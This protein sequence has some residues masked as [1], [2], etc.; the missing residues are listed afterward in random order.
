MGLACYL[1]KINS[2]RTLQASF[3]AGHFVEAYIVNELRKTCLNNGKHPN[4]FYYRDS[5]QN[6]IDLIV[7]EDGTMHCVECK[8][9][10]TFGK[11]A[12]KRAE[13]GLA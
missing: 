10:M 11:S 12:A 5:N 13:R 4:F 9:G 6:E 3:L 1:A 8:T 7:I 2:P